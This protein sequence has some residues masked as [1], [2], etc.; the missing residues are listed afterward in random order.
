MAF[1]QLETLDSYCRKTLARST[2]HFERFGPLVDHARRTVDDDTIWQHEWA[3][4]ELD[5]GEPWSHPVF[6]DTFSDEQRRAW[7]QLHWVMDYITVA[8]GE[9]QVVVLNAMAAKRF[10]PICPSVCELQDRESHEEIDHVAS[11]FEV[12]RAVERRYFGRGYVLGIQATS[13]TSSGRI[14]RGVRWLIGKG[15]DRIFGSNFPTLFF[16]TRGMKSHQF[17]PFEMAY[18]RNEASHPAMRQLSEMH[19]WDESR[20]I[21]TAQHL[22]RLANPLLDN[23][24]QENR[25]L[26]RL[27]MERLFP[28]GR[29]A[30]YRVGFWRTVLRDAPLYADVAA[31]DREALLRHVTANIHRNLGALHPIQE[32]LVTKSN[33]RIVEECGLSDEL[34]RE[35]VGFLRSD[36]TQAALVS[37]VRLEA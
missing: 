26:F 17:K 21:A 36:P 15:A 24:P 27:A 35:F 16:L 28:R 12:K 10:R 30:D 34:K 18:A 33:R 1:S 9:Q 3:P 31:E 22:A 4:R 23:V 11:F 37:S 13:G 14:N 8:Q 7:T 25:L 32:A 2:R 29:L 19:G 6:T 20:H 5:L